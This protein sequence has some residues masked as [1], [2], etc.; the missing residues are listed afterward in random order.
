VRGK[1]DEQDMEF[2]SDSFKL[3]MEGHGFLSQKDPLFE[4]YFVQDKIVS[5]GYK[6]SQC[7]DPELMMFFY[8]F[9]P[10]FHPK[11]PTYIPKKWAN[12]IIAWWTK[13]RE[14]NWAFIMHKGI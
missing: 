1:P 6:I 14:I 7:N 11:K 3:P 2:V 9:I 13:E 4:S 10:I 5:H 8:F 12:T